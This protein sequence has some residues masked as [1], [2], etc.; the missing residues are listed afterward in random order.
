MT[1]LGLAVGG[2]VPGAANAQ[3]VW[4]TAV[5][6]TFRYSTVDG[7]WGAANVAVSTP[8][9]FT[10]RREAYA[11]R[12]AFS[13]GWSTSGSYAYVA[14]AALPAY[15]E[16]WRLRVTAAATRDNRL[17]F[18][19]IGNETPYV[20]GKVTTV[21]PFYYRVSRSRGYARLTL[22]RQ[23]IGPLRVFVGGTIERTSFRSLPGATVFRTSFAGDTTQ[24]PVTDKV[25]RGGLVFDTRDNEVDPHT[26]VYLEALFAN[27]TGYTR[28]GGGARG[29]IS[30][31]PRLT[32]AGRIAGEEMTGA[33]LV[34]E[35][36][37]MES[38]EQSFVALGGYYSLRGF[39]DA[40]YIGSGK[41]LGGV[42]ARYALVWS[43]TVV[44]LVLGGFYDTGRV[45]GPG[46]SF[47]LTTNGLHHTGGGE[48][49]L[50]FLRNS[51]LVIGVG[52]GD[53]GAELL[54]AGS[55]SY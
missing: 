11:A 28:T 12:Y 17:G 9:G 46:E 55:W 39:Y 4:H 35:Q 3:R 8:I 41:L 27:G 16:G 47:Q 29:F 19:G 21:D 6:P 49:A 13:A 52:A 50:R 37:Q 44:K 7:F 23:L 25:V 36:L 22:G 40:R 31:L 45:F 48:L 42:E 51:L 15:W 2:G 30:P 14:D 20:P 34:A 43:P 18:Y 32:L 10:E 33:P 38:S 5:Y 1:L 26:G 24:S 54:F 53:E